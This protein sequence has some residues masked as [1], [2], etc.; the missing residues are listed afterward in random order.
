MAQQSIWLEE[1]LSSL[2]ELGG[3]ASLNDI[4]IKV[5]KRNKINLE[6]YIDWKSQIRKHIYLHSSDCKIFKGNAG[7]ESDIFY[8]KNGKGK[9]VWG[10][11][12][13][14]KYN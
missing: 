1:I 11:R 7:D 12:K 4:Y 8:A 9:G 14:I 10:V 3:V 2:Q 6:L 13:L 5:Q